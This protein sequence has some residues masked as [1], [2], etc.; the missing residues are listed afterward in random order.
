MRK[1][2]AKYGSRCSNAE[3]GRNSESIIENRNDLIDPNLGS[4][5]KVRPRSSS[6]S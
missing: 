2:K 3:S 6:P 4:F 1:A 5:D